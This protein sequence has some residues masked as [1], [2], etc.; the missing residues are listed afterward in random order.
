MLEKPMLK[1][2]LLVP[3]NSLVILLG[4]KAMFH[5]EE[6]RRRLAR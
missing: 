5:G 1:A 3:M 2:G 6:I 4:L